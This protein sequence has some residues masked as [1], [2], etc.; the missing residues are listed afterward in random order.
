MMLGQIYIW[1][2]DKKDWSYKVKVRF[3]NLWFYLI[4]L[5]KPS[6]T[7]LEDCILSQGKIIES[8]CSRQ[9][10]WR[11]LR[12]P[13]FSDY[14][15]L[16]L[17]ELAKIIFIG[18]PEDEREERR[19]EWEGLGSY[20]RRSLP[21]EVVLNVYWY[22]NRFDLEFPS[23]DLT[24]SFWKKL[25]KRKNKRK[26]KNIVKWFK[27]AIEVEDPGNYIDRPFGTYTVN[28]VAL[29]WWLEDERGEELLE[30]MFGNI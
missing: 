26:P 14:R 21:K 7:P 25:S 27:E 2:E 13:D 5:R 4:I 23:I 18:A 29:I 3:G 16:S 11:E 20:Y 8:V 24:F 28:L 15:D 30:E 19:I 1:K 10:R 9:E 6:T 22:P 12:K 17:Y